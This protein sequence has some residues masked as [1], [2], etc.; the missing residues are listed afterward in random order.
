M[1]HEFI[2]LKMFVI[3]PKFTDVFLFRYG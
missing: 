1:V 3:L 2:G